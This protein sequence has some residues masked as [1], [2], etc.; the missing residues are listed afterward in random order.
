MNGFA[1][2][3]EIAHAVAC[4]KQSAVGMAR[5]TLDRIKAYD[6]IQPQAWISRFPD[7]AILAAAARI[8]ERIVQG[9]TLALA[10]VAFAVKDNIDVVGLPTTAACPA[11]A[12]APVRS[13]HI[14]EKLLAA[15]A[16]CIGKTNMD[17]FATGLNGTRSPHGAPRCVFNLDYISG[18]SS[19]G[20]A[21]V[22]AA[23]L[24]AFALGT[25]TAG[26]GRV[27][28]AFNN[29]V[30]FKPTKGRWSSA[31]LVPAC[32]TLDCISLFTRDAADALLV[33]G[34]AAG[35]DLHDAYSRRIND[36][37]IGKRIAVAHMHQLDWCGDFESD[38]LYRQALARLEDSGA[39]LISVDIEPLQ[40]VAALLYQGPWV[41]ERT[42]AVADLLETRPD[43]FDP[44]VRTIVEAGRAISAVDA[45]RGLYQLAELARQAEAIW[46]SAD[47][48]LLP[49][50]PTIYRVRD[51][52]A[53]PLALNARLGLYT[54]FVNLLD[55]AA[56]AMPAGF[57]RNGT[58][59]GVTIMAPAGTD[60]ALAQIGAEWPDAL[61]TKPP[62]LAR[63]PV[64]DR[65]RLAVVGAHLKDMPLHWQLAARDA[66]F[67]AAT[68]TAPT[69]RLYAMASSTPPKP[70]LV[71]DE[72]GDAIAIEIYELDAAAFG[73]FT[74][75]VPPPL[76]IG[77]VTLAD[78]EQIKGFVAE[79]RALAGALD[80]TAFGGWRSYI[81][82]L[83]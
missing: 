12:Y 75:E 82:S 1:T 73:S 54:N 29:L 36:R 37:P 23:G 22:T 72:T 77:T 53:A 48:L 24:V 6:A 28:A 9:E 14:V 8:D 79:P 10:G 65:I 41:A 19:S 69:Y 33:D 42:A 32:R 13:A 45:F 80:I 47:V 31:G 56:V 20:S 81:G 39:S 26:S 68:F 3:R 50:T 34:I 18:G 67:I 27:P 83:A 59:F 78:G 35:Y 55:M 66:V 21:V 25:D 46:D 43:V 60:R 57:R 74:A 52:T 4:G 61:N 11:F 40:A 63:E 15:G 62:S 2:A 64:M 76:A 49:T 44:A 30:G 38:H 71:H 16:I 7:D 58:G 70:A 51:M 17:Q 5:E